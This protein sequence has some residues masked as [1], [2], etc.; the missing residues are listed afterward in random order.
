MI[1]HVSVVLSYATLA[2][3]AGP[4]DLRAPL[5]F[6]GFK[7]GEGARAERPADS[8]PVRLSP[9]PAA[10]LMQLPH[11]LAAAIFWKRRLPEWCLLSGYRCKDFF[12]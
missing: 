1:D 3:G 10:R 7:A 2:V 5:V 11:L 8:L 12:R 4:L 6:K 9:L